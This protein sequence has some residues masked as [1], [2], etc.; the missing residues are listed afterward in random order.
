M[1]ISGDNKLLAEIICLTRPIIALTVCKKRI[2]YNTL[3]NT[4]FHYIGQ[5]GNIEF[6]L[7]F[8]FPIL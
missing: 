7:G 8:K 1:V 3:I 4:R 2:V 5:L 6:S